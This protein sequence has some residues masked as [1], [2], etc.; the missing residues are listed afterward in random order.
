MMFRN[1]SRQIEIRRILDDAGDEEV[2]MNGFDS[3]L[4]IAN[5]E[6]DNANNKILKVEQRQDANDSWEDVKDSEVI[7]N[8]NNS[9]VAW[10]DLHKPKRHLK[11]TV[12]EEG[13]ECNAV[14]AIKYRFGRS[15]DVDNVVDN[16]VLGTLLSH[17]TEGTP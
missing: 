6:S 11:I 2:D 15:E 1:L 16:E 4:F 5:F 14:F 7:P 13:D 9:Q 10:L 17:P 8:G 12:E 3:I